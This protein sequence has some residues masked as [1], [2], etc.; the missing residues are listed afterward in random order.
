[1]A[2]IRIHQ[3]HHRPVDTQQWLARRATVINA[4]RAG[5]PGLIETRLIRPE[6]GT[7]LDA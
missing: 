3:L 6:D 5:H 7:F 1:M 2:A 4:I